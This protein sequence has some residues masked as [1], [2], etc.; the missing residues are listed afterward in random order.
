VV[1]PATDVIGISGV[2]RGRNRPNS[3]VLH[4]SCTAVFPAK[5]GKID[6][7]PRKSVQP[8]PIIPS[9][10]ATY[11]S[12]S[13]AVRQGSFCGLPRSE[14]VLAGNSREAQVLLHVL[15]QGP[16]DRGTACASNL[17]PRWPR[18]TTMYERARLGIRESR[19]REPIKNFCG[20]D[21]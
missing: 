6:I 7:A 12:A 21:G 3:P 5:Q 16:G 14:I 9:R 18:T 2:I 13:H 17:S 19:I 1:E 4:P 20:R 10:S 8:L 15:L 11:A